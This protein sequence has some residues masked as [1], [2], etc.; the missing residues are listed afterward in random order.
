MNDIPASDELR[1]RRR[2]LVDAAVRRLADQQ[3]GLLARRQLTELGFDHLRVR[4]QLTARRWAAR[5]D[6]VVST[7]TGELTRE[8]TMWL[9]TLH[10]GPGSLVGGLTAAEVHGLRN[11]HRDDVTILTDDDLFPEPVEGIR[12]VRTRRGLADMRWKRIGLAVCRLEPALLLWAG[13]TES[14][15]AAQGVLAAAVQQQLTTPD[16]LMLWIGR[17]RPLRRAR[18]FRSALLDIAGGSQSLAEIDVVRMCRRLGLRRPDRQQQRRDSSGRLRWTDCEWRLPSGHI[19]V[20]EVDGAFHMEVEQW[21]DDLARQRRISGPGRTVVR[22]TA[23]EVR[24]DPDQLGRDLIAL[25]VPVVGPSDR[26][27]AR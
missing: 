1:R 23:R 16:Q 3:A 7:T 18:L 21:E 25:G 8:Q 13:Y 2:A 19:V 9:G 5:S 17:M 20:L 10:A 15:R 4:N 12:F 6:L 24:D 11:W 26:Y 14:V 22:C 27:S